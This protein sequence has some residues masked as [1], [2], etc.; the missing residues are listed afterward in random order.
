MKYADIQ[1]R[2]VPNPDRNEFQMNEKMTER[3]PSPIQ[4]GASSHFSLWDDSARAI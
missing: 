3:A 4:Q 1:G 2:R